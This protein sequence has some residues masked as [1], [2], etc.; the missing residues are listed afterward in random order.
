MVAKIVVIPH[1]KKSTGSVLLRVINVR[2]R[3][4]ERRSILPPPGAKSLDVKFER[5]ARNVG[6]SSSTRVNRDLVG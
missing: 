5:F 4:A 2:F 1:R 6:R 3:L